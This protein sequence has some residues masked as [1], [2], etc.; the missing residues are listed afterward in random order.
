MVSG[1]PHPGEVSFK[2]DGC[3][4]MDIFGAIMIETEPL[5]GQ[6]IN[7]YIVKL[8]KHYLVNSINKQ[9]NVNLLSRLLTLRETETLCRPHQLHRITC[10]D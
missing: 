6:T 10:D 3:D 9:S 8:Y 1:Y 4:V 5:R 2:S 7:R